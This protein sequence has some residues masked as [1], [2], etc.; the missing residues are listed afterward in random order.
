M[1]LMPL[2]SVIL[3]Q[4]V[5]LVEETGLPRESDQSATSHWQTLSYNVVSCTPRHERGSKLTTLMVIGTNCV[6][7]FKSNYHTIT[8]TMWKCKIK[9]IVVVEK[10]IVWK[11]D[12]YR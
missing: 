10:K 2:I 1:C 3:W 6:G 11:L 4:S 5:L 9:G 12:D 7:S 8:T